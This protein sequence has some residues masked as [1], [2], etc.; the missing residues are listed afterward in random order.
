MSSILAR[1]SAVVERMRPARGRA[2]TRGTVAGNPPEDTA[3][4]WRTILAQAAAMWLIV[5][6][7]LGLVTTYVVGYVHHAHLSAAVLVRVWEQWDGGW[8]VSIGANG[9]QTPA[10]A[11][12]FPLYPLLIHAGTLVLGRRGALV[13][14]MLVSNLASLA[15]FGGIG[16]LAAYEAHAQDAAWRAIR[17][18]A[19]YPLAFYL[20]APYTEGPF[21]ALSVFAIYCARRGSW[22]WAAACAFC[23]GLVRPT[24]IVLELP[25]VWEFGRQHGW[26][27]RE[28][29]DVAR[30]RAASRR[31]LHRQW[32]HSGVAL[33]P[34]ATLT[35]LLVIVAVPAAFACVAAYDAAR[36]GDPL[37][38]VHAQDSYW[39]HAQWTV[40]HTTAAIISSLLHPP[41]TYYWR[42]LIL[43]DIT[44][45]VVCVVITLAMIRRIPFA[46]TLYMAGLLY[47][48]VTAPVPSRPEVIP[49][50][51]RYLLVAFPVVLILG[52]WT[53][54][55]PWLEF[56]ILC[57]GFMLQ[58]MFATMFLS[59]TWIE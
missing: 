38:Y 7:M 34:R 51:A 31:W 54:R 37:L 21:L 41:A 6:V 3:P 16:L 35:A 42:M 11:G 44:A 32:L 15:A 29:W 46:F 26:W 8:Y 12:F 53:E 58:A 33:R 1:G 25:L 57:G 48:L 27:R 43:V 47:L 36:F 39:H 17:V 10:A 28:V 4:W 5:R 56:L 20:V 52:R 49:S 14:A 45:V 50:A 59:G 19:A 24:G 13:S 55:R 40:W 9:Y 18:T 2:Y 30:W 22:R 23:A